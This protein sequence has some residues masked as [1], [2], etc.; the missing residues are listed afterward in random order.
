[1]YVNSNVI[2]INDPANLYKLYGTAYIYIVKW[3]FIN[4]IEA[5]A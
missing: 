3:P 2:K 4:D 5:L 1:M